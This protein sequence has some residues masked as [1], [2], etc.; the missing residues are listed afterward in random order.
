MIAQ[1]LN[2]QCAYDLRLLSREP[3]KIGMDDGGPPGV[4][5]NLPSHATAAA[6]RKAR[7][8]RCGSHISLKLDVLPQIVGGY[9]RRVDGAGGIRRD[10]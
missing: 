3:G 1:E 10:T 8:E 2:E 5:A 9:V 4:I 7:R 6:A